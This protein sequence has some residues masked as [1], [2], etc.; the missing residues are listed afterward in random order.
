MHLLNLTSWAKRIDKFDYI[1]YMYQLKET[2][3][4]CYQQG[5]KYDEKN[6]KKDNTFE[7]SHYLFAGQCMDNVGRSY[8]WITSGS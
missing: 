6:E 1:C 3:K 8:L 5:E 2:W 7:Y 4:T